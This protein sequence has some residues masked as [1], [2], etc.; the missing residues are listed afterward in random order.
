MQDRVLSKF[1]WQII[2]LLSPL[3]QKIGNSCRSSSSTEM[4]NPTVGM[5]G[6]VVLPQRAELFPVYQMHEVKELPPLLLQVQ[7][8]SAVLDSV[9][10]K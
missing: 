4:N 10:Y 8:M 1:I 5:F 3:N 2:Y 6:T 9:F 7:K